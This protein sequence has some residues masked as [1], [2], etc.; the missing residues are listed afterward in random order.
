VFT[1]GVVVKVIAAWWLSEP[2]VAV[3]VRVALPEGVTSDVTTE[4]D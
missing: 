2:L 4:N 3:S 1:A